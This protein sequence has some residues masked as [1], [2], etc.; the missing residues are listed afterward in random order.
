MA[1]VGAC[2]KLDLDA[3]DLGFEV[4]ALL[5]AEGNGG[6]EEPDELDSRVK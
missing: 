1:I 6:R 4:R 3:A 2:E 5:G